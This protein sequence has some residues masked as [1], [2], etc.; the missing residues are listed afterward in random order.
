MGLAQSADTRMCLSAHKQAQLDRADGKLK[1]SRDQLFRCARRECPAPVRA[2]CSGWLDEVS[3]ALP[4]L[5]IQVRDAQG[6]D[7]SDVRVF[8]DGELLTSR[9]DG[10]PLDVD[11][12]AQT[13]RFEAKDGR[14]LEQSVIVRQGEKDR[15]LQVRFEPARAPKNKSRKPPVASRPPPEG[16]PEPGQ[17]APTLSYVLMGVGGVGVGAF[18]YFAATGFSRE[19]D[20]KDQCAPRCSQSEIDSVRHRYIAAD[21]SLGVGVAALAIGGWLWLGSDRGD[22]H[23]G[24]SGLRLGLGTRGIMLGGPL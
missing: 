21:V 22:S 4:T 19:S 7:L 8:V 5:V 20:L 1:A 18:G 6:A 14:R 23:T 24:A 11:P 16:R 13:F 3:A 2:E 15:L 10:R 9:L 17:G 12:G